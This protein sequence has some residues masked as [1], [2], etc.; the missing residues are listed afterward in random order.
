MGGWTGRAGESGP[1]YC[2]QSNFSSSVT[3]SLGPGSDLGILGLS[4]VVWVAGRG[5]AQAEVVFLD[6][7]YIGI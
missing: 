7:W 6:M 3:R 4:T 2:L 5:P 1:V